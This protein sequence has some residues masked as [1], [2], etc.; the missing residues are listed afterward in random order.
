MTHNEPSEDLSGMIQEKPTE[1][2]TSKMQ[3][4]NI[5]DVKSSITPYLLY[6]I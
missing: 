1:Y 2:Q 3:N 5:L 4:T 6:A